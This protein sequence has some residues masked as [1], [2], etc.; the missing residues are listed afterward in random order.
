MIEIQ[1]EEAKIIACMWV[2]YMIKVQA[3]E[4][5]WEKVS[6]EDKLAT[7]LYNLKVLIFLSTE[8]MKLSKVWK[9][10][11]NEYTSKQLHFVTS[12]VLTLSV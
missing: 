8:S 5:K 6:A 2:L 11:K 3:E 7:T 1:A 10:W 12:G 9:V 4:A